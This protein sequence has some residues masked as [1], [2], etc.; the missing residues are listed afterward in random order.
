EA[1]GLLV[2]RY[3]ARVIALCA[4]ISGDREQAQ[5]LAQEAFVRAYTNLARYQPGRSFFAW[6]YRIAVNGALN[7]RSRRPPA[8]LRGEQG[9]LALLTAADPGPSPEA[10]AAQADLARQLQAAIARLPSEYTTVLALRYGAD[11][12][13]AAIA[14]TLDVPLGTVKARLFRAKALL[15]PLVEPLLA[16]ELG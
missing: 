7:Y 5:D 16:E 15:R 13:Y 14:A 12:D 1:F 11:L 6:L 4:Q 2:E 10:Q 3:Q 9:E 8:P